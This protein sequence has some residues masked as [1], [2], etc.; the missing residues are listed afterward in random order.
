MTSTDPA[1]Q[2]NDE[3]LTTIVVD[4]FYPHP[5]ERVWRALTTPELLAQWLMPNDFRAEVGHRFTMRGRPVEAT[6]FSGVV[7]STVLAVEAPRLLRISWADA[8]GGNA[9]QT[10]VTWTLQAEGAGT[11]VLLEQAGFDADDAVDQLSRRIM[12]GGWRSMI[13]ARLGEILDDA[14]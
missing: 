3:D 1:T 12:T 4:Q 14:A 6:G 5:P 9:M 11:R 10:T 13:L 8:E 2:S 7:A